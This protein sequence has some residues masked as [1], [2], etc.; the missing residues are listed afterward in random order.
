MNAN[1]QSFDNILSELW[2]FFG[3]P[4]LNFI[5][6][7][8]LIYPIVSA[9][10]VETLSA[11]AD[12]NADAQSI[13]LTCPNPDAPAVTTDLPGGV[14][15]KTATSLYC[16][17][18]NDPIAEI[19]QASTSLI[20]TLGILVFLLHVCTQWLGTVTMFLLDKTGATLAFSNNIH[21]IL[22][23]TPKAIGDMIRK[24]FND[25]NITDFSAANEDRLEREH[26]YCVVA[27]D[28]REGLERYRNKRSGLSDQI[29][30]LHHYGA[31]SIAY[32]VLWFALAIAAGF[33]YGPGAIASSLLIHFVT[34]VGAVALYRYA[35]TAYYKASGEAI[36]LDMEVYSVNAEID[37]RTKPASDP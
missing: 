33:L 23:N 36:L 3:A 8:T 15:Q 30:N 5:F 6:M 11:P 25:F 26:L 7:C 31:Y 27:N 10:V 34:I 20:V 21:T 13:V 18:L 22:A 17:F 37:H 14:L 24:R 1:W 16:N 28:R 35:R 2:K 4:L 19:I 32:V 12:P 29:S 9:T